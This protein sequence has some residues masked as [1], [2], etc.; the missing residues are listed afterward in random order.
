MF[1]LVDTKTGKSVMKYHLLKHA[2]LMAPGYRLSSWEI[3]DSEGRCLVWFKVY[4]PAASH[5]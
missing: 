2:K 1:E 3:R 5:A 4:N